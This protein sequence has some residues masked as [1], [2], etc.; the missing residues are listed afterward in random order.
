LFLEALFV[1]TVADAKHKIEA[2]R[3]AKIFMFLK[4]SLDEHLSLQSLLEI[5]RV[6]RSI[7]PIT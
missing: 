6:R 2:R 5:S 7:F 1:A 3:I 4:R